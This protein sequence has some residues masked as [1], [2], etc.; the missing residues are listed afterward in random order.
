MVDL[1]SEY[2][3]NNTKVPNWIKTVLDTEKEA[4]PIM[5]FDEYTQ[6]LIH[7]RLR[8]RLRQDSFYAKHL[9]K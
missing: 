4:S 1:A 8:D 2:K 6:Q 5:N 9:I 3:K 7:G